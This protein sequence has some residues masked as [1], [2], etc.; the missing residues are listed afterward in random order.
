M[1]KLLLGLIALMILS[2]SEK[3]TFTYFGGEIVNPKE[4]KV[5]L[6]FKD[7]KIDSSSLDENNRF[8]F[9][10]NEFTEGVYSFSHGNE[11]QYIILEN[12][13]SLLLRLNTLE[14]DESLMF[15][16]QGAVKNNFL[17]DMWLLQEDEGYLMKKFYNAN[18][19]V[20][21]RKMDSIRSMK[22]DEYEQMVAE[23][24]LSPLAKHVTKA[25]IDLPHFTYKERYASEHKYRLGLE[26]LPKVPAGYYEHREKVNINDEQLAD[27]GLYFDYLSVY[28]D[29]LTRDRCKSKC[30]LPG[31]KLKVYHYSTHRLNLIDS[32]ITLPHLRSSFMERTAIKYFQYDHNEESNRDFIAFYKDLNNGEISPDLNRMHNAVANLRSGNAIPPLKLYDQKGDKHIIDSTW[33]DKKTVFYLWTSM[34]KRHARKTLRHV[35]QLKKAYPEFQFISINLDASHDEW[36]NSMN[37]FGLEGDLHMRAP[38]MRY[39]IKHFAYLHLDR[40]VVVNEEGKVIEGFGNIYNTAPL[41]YSRVHEKLANMKKI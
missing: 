21:V 5:Y 2:C 8:H 20:F 1:N 23:T 10:L 12:E 34:E 39:I 33:F 25:S 17:I 41:K 7:A 18:P 37:E 6:L 24:D 13:D 15:T 26:E 30:G 22:I 9:K 16:G 19:E 40:M 31:G 11:L 29:Q 28:L 35:Q 3:E 14:F 27:L 36:L 32:L 38:G 4:D